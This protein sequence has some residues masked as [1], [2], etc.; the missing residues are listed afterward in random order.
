MA[1]LFDDLAGA[2]AGVGVGVLLEEVEV[3]ELDDTEVVVVNAVDGR[4]GNVEA[5]APWPD[6][7]VVG[8]TV[9]VTFTSLAVALNSSYAAM[10]GGFITPT[11]PD[12]QW[13]EGSVFAQ[14]NQIG[15]VT[16]V[17][18][19]SQVGGITLGPEALPTPAT[20]LLKPPGI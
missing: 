4:G 7:A 19:K 13:K 20:P 1:P 12:A 11:I 5:V 10:E 2:G 17:I 16:F 8:L 15:S 14:K 3:V 6:S 9:G 18:C